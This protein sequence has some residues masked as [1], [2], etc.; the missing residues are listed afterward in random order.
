M[1]IS[2]VI[3]PIR[4]EFICPRDLSARFALES[5]EK[6]AKVFL[7]GQIWSILWTICPTVFPASKRGLEVFESPLTTDHYP[8][9]S[10]LG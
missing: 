7:R 3:N 2:E 8:W 1:G 9:R 5:P 4:T 6:Q 10:P